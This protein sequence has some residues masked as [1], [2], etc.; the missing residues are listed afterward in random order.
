MRD[1]RWKIRGNGRG[2][3]HGV[4]SGCRRQRVSRCPDGVLIAR[5]NC[6][7]KIQQ[8]A[9]VIDAGMIGML[10]AV[11]GAN[12]DVI[13]SLHFGAHPEHHRVCGGS[14]EALVEG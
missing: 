7:C 3:H 1:I 2:I 8:L 6:L 12:V 11:N 10:T 13:V 4:H 5:C 9:T 14:V